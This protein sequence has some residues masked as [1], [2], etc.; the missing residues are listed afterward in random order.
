MRK[1]RSLI[2]PQARTLARDWGGHD[3]YHPFD[4]LLSERVMEREIARRKLPRRAPVLV[5]VVPLEDGDGEEIL[6]ISPDRAALERVVDAFERGGLPVFA[7]PIERPE[8]E[9]LEELL[10]DGLLPPMLAPYVEPYDDEAPPRR[11][12]HRR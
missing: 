12:R 7:R 10:G 9:Q 1:R 6:L 2:P 3:G 8:E 11:R 5:D 4:G